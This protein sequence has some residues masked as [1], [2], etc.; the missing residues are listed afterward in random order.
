MPANNRVGIVLAG[1]ASRRMQAAGMTGMTG[2][3]AWSDKA[4]L[5]LDGQAGGQSAGQTFVE[6]VCLAV[7]AEVGEVIVVAA[8]FQ[9]LPSLPSGVMVVRDSLPG[10]GPLAGVAD[11]MRCVLEA[12][13]RAGR[14]PPEAA[15][16]ASCDVPLLRPAVVRL[17]CEALGCADPVRTGG[18]ASA[19]P[20]RASGTPL[21]VVPVV[22]GYR[23]VLVSALRLE[24]L[25][26]IEAYLGSGRRDP[27]GLL[28]QIHAAD[29]AA[30]CFVCEAEIAAVDPDGDSFCDVDTWADF[31]RINSRLQKNDG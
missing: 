26:T 25:A 14:T 21:W 5:T 16:I 23:Q 8:P 18:Q 20:C 1:G 9:E 6:R 12:R 27:R 17:L 22:G 30:V 2:M 7:A 10:A 31:H 28:E 15:V 4:T 24:L 11:G 29:P 13:R 19:K 3:N